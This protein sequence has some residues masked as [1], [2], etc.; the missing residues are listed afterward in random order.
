MTQKKPEKKECN[1]HN[2][3][4]EISILNKTI[5]ECTAWHKQEIIN[6][7]HTI[8]MLEGENEL[9]RE[10]IDKHNREM[11]KVL[12]GLKMPILDWENNV[13]GQ[14]MRKVTEEFNQ[15]INQTIKKVS[16]ET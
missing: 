10:K 1:N 2:D 13:Q 7:E 3:C 4:T 15:R 11:V 5:D 9:Y 14:L 6:R 12:E 8:L 16:H